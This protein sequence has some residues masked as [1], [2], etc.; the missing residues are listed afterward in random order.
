MKDNET[1]L[2]EEMRN[3]WKT[4]RKETNQM[5]R[6]RWKNNIEMDIREIWL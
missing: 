3:D 5:T 2:M 1:A 4:L 6:I